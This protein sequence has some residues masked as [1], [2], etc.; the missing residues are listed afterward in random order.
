LHYRC[1]CNFVGW[2]RGLTVRPVDLYPALKALLLVGAVTLL[3]FVLN[4]LVD[5]KHIAI[6]YLIPVMICATRWGTVAAVIAAIAGL[7]CADF[8]FYPPLYTFTVDDPQQILDLVLFVIVAIVTGYLANNLRSQAAIARLHENDMRDLYAFSRRLAQCESAP[9]IYTAIEDH[10]SRTIQ[11]RAVLIGVARENANGTM[12]GTVIPDLVRR[13]AG[14]IA[15]QRGSTPATVVDAAPG[16]L[17]LVRPVSAKTPELG[18]VAI[19][20]AAESREAANEITQ[21]VDAVLAAAAET[22][23]R[24]DVA[25][26][27]NDARLRAETNLLRDALIGSV[28]HELRTPLAAILG[29]A[30]VIVGA[31]AIAQ[32]PRL[33]SLAELVRDEAEHLNSDIQNLLDATRITAQ[34]VQPKREWADPTD[35]VNVAVERRR[36]RLA[37]HRIDM[38]LDGELAL[39][40]VDPILLEQA[41][42]QILGNA[43]KY[44][45]AGSTIMVKAYPN[46]DRVVLSVQDQGA[47]LTA[48]EQGR[49]GER[50]FRGRRHEVT[51]AGS[52]LG[53]WI[54]QA[55][56]EANGGMVESSSEGEGRGTT[57][58]FS[59]PIPDAAEPQISDADDE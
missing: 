2:P 22:L 52:G 30:S 48:D 8:F 47:G 51:T 31:P 36:R 59:F 38:E 45:P 50:A 42:G 9:D 39:L 40:H 23:E 20:L 1:G 12:R 26:A 46:A 58:A 37:N 25:R 57:V 33:A 35:I 10:L 21:R 54:A 56:V 27:I 5:F 53:V 19:D 3:L 55:F 6:V 32:D 16:R 34:G 11:H 44:S 29:A 41:L 28:S 24:L 49:L 18:T 17:W 7:A 43:A 4:P 14:A 13:E 15:E